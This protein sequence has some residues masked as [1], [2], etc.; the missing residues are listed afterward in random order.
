MEDS[1]FV[2]IQMAGKRGFKA[3]VFSHAIRVK[4]WQEHLGLLNPPTKKHALLREVIL[5]PGQS[6]RS[7]R[8]LGL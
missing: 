4:L 2:E 6:S 7:A 5:K 3:G 1:E 8:S